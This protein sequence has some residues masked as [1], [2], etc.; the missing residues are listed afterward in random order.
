[1]VERAAD[2]AARMVA[3]NTARP[4]F[5]SGQR[6]RHADYGDGVLAA[7]VELRPKLGETHHPVADLAFY[8]S[9]FAEVGW[10]FRGNDPGPPLPSVGVA[11]YVLWQGAAE[12]RPAT[13]RAPLAADALLADL[14]RRGVLAPPL[15]VR[16]GPPPRVPVGPTRQ[17]LEELT[18]D[19]GDR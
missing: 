16:E 18:G 12:L 19:R 17:L 7:M 5:E 11:P 1:V 9:T 15:M 2:L 6:V 8:V 4:T 13:E 3:G 10:L 14:V